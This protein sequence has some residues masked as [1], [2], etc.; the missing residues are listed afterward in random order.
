MIRQHTF[1]SQ[2]HINR[3]ITHF[4]TIVPLKGKWNQTTTAQ[5]RK[6]LIPLGVMGLRMMRNSST[7]SMKNSVMLQMANIG[8]IL[9]HSHVISSKQQSQ[10]PVARS[11]NREES[12]R[13]LVS[14]AFIRAHAKLEKANALS[15]PT[16]KPTKIDSV[17]TDLSRRLIRRRSTKETKVVA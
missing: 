9:Q 5:S 6:K 10:W 1:P 16:P 12:A 17:R 13:A 14:R 4:E 7:Q 3:C 8:T 15:V 11:N 2:R